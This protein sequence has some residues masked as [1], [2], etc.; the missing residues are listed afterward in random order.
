MDMDHFKMHVDPGPGAIVRM[1]ET[2]LDPMKTDALFISHRHPDH[3]SDAEIMIVAMTAGKKELAGS[4]FGSQSA[5]DGVKGESPSI[6]EYLQGKLLHR[7]AMFSGDAV[8]TGRCTITAKPAYHSD[9]STVGF[10]LT[11]GIFTLGY[12]PDTEYHSSLC[13]EYSG[14][15]V[16]VLSLTRPKG[17]RISYHLCTQDAKKL[18]LGAKPKRAILTHFGERMIRWGPQ[19]EAAYLHEETGINVIAAKDGEIVKIER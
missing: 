16:L 12:L 1:K 10:T 5:L 8:S 9:P 14:C 17:D 15:D 18:I 4:I 3:C 11:D 6:S 19:K 7:Q 13:A 2:G